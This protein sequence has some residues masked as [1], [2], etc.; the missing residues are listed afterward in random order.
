MIT[1][2]NP[3]IINIT[4]AALMCSQVFCQGQGMCTRKNADSSEYLH[5]NPMNFIIGSFGNGT[6]GILGTPSMEDLKQFAE[7]FQCSCYS[8]TDCEK[9][10]NFTQTITIDVCMIEDVCIRATVRSKNEIFHSSASLVLFLLFLI[11][12][13]NEYSGMKIRL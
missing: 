9:E 7:H 8:N 5:L 6:F 13:E 1:T 2:M 12:L 10:V 11:V 3:Y 4:L